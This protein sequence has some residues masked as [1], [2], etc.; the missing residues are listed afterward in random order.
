MTQE[1][2]ILRHLLEGRTLTPLNALNLYGTMRLAARVHNLKAAGHDIKAQI[3][4][5]PSGKHIC[6]YYMGAL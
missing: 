3:I 6:R 4:K 2:S 1:Q 5:L